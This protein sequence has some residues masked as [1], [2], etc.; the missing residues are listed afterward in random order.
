MSGFDKG[1]N[2]AGGRSRGEVSLKVLKP[3]FAESA[4]NHLTRHL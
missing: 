1:R 4:A 2:L 3:Y